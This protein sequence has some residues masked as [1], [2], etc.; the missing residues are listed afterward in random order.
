MKNENVSAWVSQIEGNIN[1]LNM[2]NVSKTNIAEIQRQINMLSLVTSEI[3]KVNKAEEKRVKDQEKEQKKIEQNIQRQQQ[4]YAGLFNQIERT[5]QQQSGALNT[6]MQNAL[7]LGVKISGLSPDSTTVLEHQLERYKNIIRRFQESNELGIRI[8]PEQLTQLQ[9]LENRIRRFYETVRQ[10]QSDSRGFN[11]TQYEE[12]NR[13]NPAITNATRAQQ[14]YNTSLLEG[15][16]LIGA[17]IQQTDQYIRVMQQLRRGSE[18]LNLGV[19][20]DRATGQMYQFNEALRDGMTRSWG[21]GEAMS[22][23]ATKVTNK[24]NKNILLPRMYRNVHRTQHAYAG[25]S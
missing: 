2:S 16:R 1:K 21:L 11:F 22:T 17:N 6:R 15:Y 12:F 23:A 18:H 24:I 5:L 20:I 7:G 14:Y 9:N 3:N 19:Y 25:N 4:L 8:R 13:L 10:G